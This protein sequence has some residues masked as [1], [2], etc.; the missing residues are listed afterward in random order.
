MKCSA[1]SLRAAADDTSQKETI[2][3]TELDRALAG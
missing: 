1:P 3:I 2:A